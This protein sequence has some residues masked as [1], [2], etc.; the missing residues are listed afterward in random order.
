MWL[1]TIH[2]SFRPSPVL[3]LVAISG[4]TCTQPMMFPRLETCKATATG[5]FL[6]CTHFQTGSK[7]PEFSGTVV[8]ARA[9]QYSTKAPTVFRSWYLIVIAVATGNDHSAHHY[10]LRGVALPTPSRSIGPFSASYGFL[11][12]DKSEKCIH[13]LNRQLEP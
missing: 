7:L 1:L 4:I 10:T 12:I 5:V 6:T 13:F 2:H 8:S 9:N 3:L 11:G